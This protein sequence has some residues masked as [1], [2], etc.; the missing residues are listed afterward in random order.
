MKNETNL[1]EKEKFSVRDYFLEHYLHEKVGKDGAYSRKTILAR[2][3][4]RLPHTSW[5]IPRT[6]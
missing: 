1:I 6:Q 4:P 2:K 3:A 5:Y